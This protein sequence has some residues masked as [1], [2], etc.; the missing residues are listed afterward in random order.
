MCRIIFLSFVK[1]GIWFTN[2]PSLGVF[3]T[4][5]EVPGCYDEIKFVATKT[6]KIVYG[7]NS[8]L[9]SMSIEE[10]ARVNVYANA[11]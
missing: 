5:R 2:D 10:E 8:M 11:I 6:H 4:I 9:H 3:H 7:R 1:S